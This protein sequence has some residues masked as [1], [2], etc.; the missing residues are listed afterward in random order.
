MIEFATNASLPE[1]RKIWQSVFLD[2]NSYLDLYF[3]HYIKPEN[4]LIYRENGKLT[5][6]LNMVEYNFSFYNETLPCYY[7]T[8][9]ATYPEHRRKGHMEALICESLVIMLKRGIPLS[10]LIPGEEWLYNFYSRYGFSQTF[11]ANSEIIDLKG[12]I[13]KSVDMEDAYKQFDAK[14]NKDSFQIKKSKDDF[15]TI[16][17]ESKLYDYITKTDLDGMSRSINVYELLKIF[18][19]NNP[20]KKF[21]LK[22]FGDK[23][24][25]QNNGFYTIEDATVS[26]FLSAKADIEIS[27][28]DFCQLILGYSNEELPPRYYH[29]F[30]KHKTSLSLML[31]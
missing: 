18:A 11:E 31:D 10:I 20:K 3:S 14:Y 25:L 6:C 5:A 1:I 8:A 12:I 4:S 13:D 26:K 21:T 27:I 17:K 15:A 29:Y 22:I 9:L 2:D 24:L 7:L 23:Q 28:G 30:P 16:I 19:K